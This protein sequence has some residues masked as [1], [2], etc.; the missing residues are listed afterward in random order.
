MA[1]LSMRERE[2]VSQLWAAGQRRKAIADGWVAAAAPL[3]A[4]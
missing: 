3:A 1:Q 2:I 4:N